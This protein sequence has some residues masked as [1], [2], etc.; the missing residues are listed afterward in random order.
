[1]VPKGEELREIFYYLGLVTQLGLTVVCSI[2][3][4]FGLGYF[5]DK[6]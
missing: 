2:L 4:G 6:K 1:M 3:I 5:L